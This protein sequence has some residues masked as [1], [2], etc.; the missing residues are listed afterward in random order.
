[1]P[2]LH[3]EVLR[4]S[5]LTLPGA[6]A[7]GFVAQPGKVILQDAEGGL[8]HYQGWSAFRT[9]QANHLLGKPARGRSGLKIDGTQKQ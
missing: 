3:V 2:T 1:M 9:H 8:H 5:W 6:N 4:Q 7:R